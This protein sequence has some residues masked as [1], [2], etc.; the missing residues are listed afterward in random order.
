VKLALK[1]LTVLAVFAIFV[2]AVYITV[3]DEPSEA[4]HAPQTGIEKLIAGGA[5]VLFVCAHADD[6]AFAAP[7]LAQTGKNGMALTLGAG[8]SHWDRAC[9]ILGIEGRA[10]GFPT[11]AAQQG[12]PRIRPQDVKNV[13]ISQW[14]DSGRD[15]RTP[16]IEAIRD[17]KPD[18][19][20]T[21]DA[22]QGFTGDK[23]HRA[24]GE[25]VVAVF[26]EEPQ[27]K[28][29]YCIVNRFPRML[30]GTAPAI[31][32]SQI[33]EIASSRTM[34]SDGRTALQKATEVLDVFSASGSHEIQ[35]F[36]GQE[37]ERLL[38]ETALLIAAQR[39]SAK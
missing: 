33:V 3:R 22:D 8:G 25:L 7:L 11:R 17:F 39:R 38:R 36:S 37:W 2:Y 34:L 15:P 31:S 28:V 9:G 6:L 23:E 13:V 32:R 12:E 27:P 30:G 29:V 21:F 20:L 16:I 26:E 5:R 1:A 19:L 24:V 4:V 18:I 10:A 14:L 35:K